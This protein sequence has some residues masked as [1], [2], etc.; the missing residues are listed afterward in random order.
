MCSSDLVEAVEHPL[1]DPM[2]NAERRR[3][4]VSELLAGLQGFTP[5]AVYLGCTHFPH[6]WPELSAALPKGVH[7]I[8]PARSLV[9]F[10]GSYLALRGL[11]AKA[12]SSKR[13]E[14]D[15]L[16]TNGSLARLTSV[17]EQLGY[18]GRVSLRQVDIRNDFS[19]KQVDVLGFGATE[20]GRAHV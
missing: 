7:L 20:I 18:G 2:A 5:E 15:A 14:G 1:T 10:L 3:R 16:F 6:L 12:R 13:E 19:G 9:H 4:V 8:N 11:A 17:L